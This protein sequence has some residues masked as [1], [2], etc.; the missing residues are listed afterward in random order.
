[1]LEVYHDE[2][3]EKLEILYEKA[4]LE[5]PEAFLLAN[6]NGINAYII[7]WDKKLLGSTYITFLYQGNG[8]VK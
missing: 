5:N 6:I 2:N 7:K 8:E 3:I 4:Y 1:M